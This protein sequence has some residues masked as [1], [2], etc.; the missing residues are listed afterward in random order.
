MDASAIRP[1]DRL[2]AERAR[3][4][5]LALAAVQRLA[6]GFEAGALPFSEARLFDSAVYAHQA[7]AILAGRF[8]DPSLVAFGPLYGWFLAAVGDAWL[9]AQLALG[10]GT[11]FLIERIAARHSPAAGLFALA[12]WIGYALP[13]FYETKMM[14]ETLGLFFLVVAVYLVLDPGARPLRL[15][16]GGAALGLAVLTRAN[17]LFALPFFLLAALRPT[18]T[19][20]TFAARGRSA[21]AVGLGL[22]LVLGANGAW[23]AAW[24]GRFVPVILV[25]RTA[26]V[27]SSQGGWTGSLETLAT[28]GAPS[29][30]DVVRQAEQTLASGEQS[31]GPLQIDL[32]GWVRS[33]PS[34]LARTFSDVETT[35]QYGF[36]GERTEV[37]S[38]AW[39]PI[40]FGTLLVL[41]ALGAALV[42]RR[43]GVGA[44]LEH[45][46][47]ILCVVLVTTLFHPS[48]RYRLPMIVP[49]V[50]LG[51]AG[52]VELFR[53]EQAALRRGIVAAV[54]V[55]C[56][57]L[58]IRHW[59][60]ALAHP[61]M[62]ELQVAE[63]EYARGHVDASAARVVRAM[64]LSE[65]GDETRRR[66]DVLRT[67]RALPH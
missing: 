23:N 22:A 58:A 13:L 66:I 32:L 48:S 20:S 39:Q 9:P 41:A 65:E 63:G 5:L 3:W 60:H 33:A 53:I 43:R 67:H 50:A 6:Y 57:A 62:W 26:S 28:A 47:L 30:W 46:P 35:F 38:L 31:D 12:L 4:Y 56:G 18:E 54:I 8:D 27:A 11:A 34:K 17:L 49:L 25:S 59:T 10:V 61:A 64:E 37:R 2:G 36:Y 45:A 44:V 51:S 52:I 21:A 1:S 55:V 15:L 40:S 42:G 24:F 14:S 16:G 29:A 7:S 19:A